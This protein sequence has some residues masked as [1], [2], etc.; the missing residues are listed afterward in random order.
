MSEPTTSALEERLKTDLKDAMRARDQVRVDTIRLAL[1]AFHQEEVARTD[2]KHRQHRQPLTETDRISLI[3]RQ[4]KQREEAAQIFRSAGRTESA[5]K[6][7]RE[8]AILKSYLPAQLS[9]DELRAIITA[10]VAREGSDF[11]KVMPAAVRETKGRA[12][13]RSVQQIVRE[14]TS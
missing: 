14:L 8:A 2:A 10:I 5:D 4:V 6:E 3:E 1:N 11:K 12:D 13:G 9:E 7:E